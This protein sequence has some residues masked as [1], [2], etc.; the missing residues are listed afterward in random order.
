MRKIELNLHLICKKKNNEQERIEILSKEEINTKF[1]R[2][3]NLKKHLKA[4]YKEIK[5]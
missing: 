5:F 4:S 1:K 3:K 2:L